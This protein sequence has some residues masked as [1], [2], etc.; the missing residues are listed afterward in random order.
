MRHMLQMCMVPRRRGAL[1]AGAIALLLALVGAAAPA[2]AGDLAITAFSCDVPTQQGYLVADDVSVQCSVTISESGLVLAPAGYPVRILLDSYTTVFGV[3]TSVAD[4]RVLDA[5][6]KLTN[7]LGGAKER[8]VV[9]TAVDDLTGDDMDAWLIDQWDAGRVLVLSA[10]VDPTDRIV[11]TDES[12]NTATM[13]PFL[14]SFR[15]APLSGKVAFGPATV[16][17]GAGHAQ[18]PGVCAAADLQLSADA[19]GTWRAGGAFGPLPVDMGKACVVVAS[20]GAGGLNLA[21][22]PGGILALPGLSASFG[23][24]QATIDVTLTGAGAVVS[25]GTLALPADHTFHEE[26]GGFPLPRG[27]RTLPM[28]TASLAGAGTLN[29]LKLSRSAG[30]LHAHGLPFYLHV[31]SI[32]ADRKRVE[33]LHSGTRWVHKRA[34]LNDDPRAPVVLG[35]SRV[36]SNDIRFANPAFIQANNRFRLAAAG[37][38]ATVTFGPGVGD[39]HFPQAS[40]AWLPVNLSIAKGAIKSQSLPGDVL[41]KMVQSATCGACT[42]GAL[43]DVAFAV[44][45]TGRMGIGSDGAVLARVDGLEDAAWGGFDPALGHVFERDGD[46]AHAGVLLF[47]GAIATGTGGVGGPSVASSLLGA[48]EAKVVSGALRPAAHHLLEDAATQKG[49][50]FVA[51]LTV[52]PALYDKAGAPVVGVGESLVGTTTRVRLGGL[53]QPGPCA[54]GPCELASNEATRFVVR[55]GGV[56]GVFDTDTPPTP[57]VYGYELPLTRFAFRQVLNTVDPVSGLEGAVSVPAPGEFTV[58]FES[59]GFDCTGALTEAVVPPCPVGGGADDP[60]C[61]ETLRAWKTRMDLLSMGFASIPGALVCEPGLRKLEVGSELDIR[62]LSA[63]LGL[64]AQ[65]LP[66]GTPTAVR[67]TGATDHVLDADAG[68]KVPGFPVALHPAPNLEWASIDDGWYAFTVDFATPLFDA[69]TADARLANTTLDTRA[70]TWVRA[71]G[72]DWTKEGPC[73]RA[74]FPDDDAALAACAPTAHYTWGATGFDVDLQAWYDGA[75]AGFTGVTREHSLAVMNIRAA[76]AQLTADAVTVTFGASAELEDLALAAIDLSIDLDDPAS[77]AKTDAYLA[78]IGVGGAPIGSIVE[79]VRGAVDGVL[80]SLGGELDLQLRGVIQGAIGAAADQVAGTVVGQTA[81][82]AAAELLLAVRGIPASFAAEASLSLEPLRAELTAGLTATLDAKARALFHAYASIFAR[83]ELAPCAVDPSLPCD[84]ALAQVRELREQ[85]ALIRGTLDDLAGRLADAEARLTALVD[86][87]QALTTDARAMLAALT[88][89]V[90]VDDATVT[91]FVSGDVTTNQLLGLLLY[92]LAPSLRDAME[93]F[94]VVD[95]VSNLSKLAELVPLPATVSEAQSDIRGTAEELIAD[96]DQTLVSFEAQ[97][98]L[99]DLSTILDGATGFLDDLDLLLAVASTQLGWLESALA[100]PFDALSDALSASDDLLAQA[101]A[102]LAGIEEDLLCAMDP[103]CLGVE[104]SAMASVAI[105]AELNARLKAAT[106]G[107]LAFVADVGGVE[108]SFVLQLV[109]VLGEPL[110]LAIAD[111][112]L[113]VEL[114]LP[115]LFDLP[116]FASAA[117]LRDTL[118]DLVMNAPGIEALILTFQQHF[119][120]LVVEVAALS[121]ELFDQVE[122]A[123]N[124]LATALED[125][126]NKVLAA[127]NGAIDDLTADLPIEAA[128]LDGVAVVA[129][130]ELSSLHVGAAWTMRGQQ[131]EDSRTFEAALDVTAWST[132]GKG[133]ACDGAASQSALLDAVISTRNLPLRVGAGEVTIETLELGFTLDGSTGVPKPVGLFGGITTDGGLD[134]ESFRI[135][136]IAFAAGAGLYE[137]Y[138]GAKASASFSAT[139][140]S[141]GFLVGRTC[142]LDVLESLDPQVAEFLTL[143]ASGFSGV[144]ARGSAGFPLIDLGC[145]LRLSLSADVGTWLLGGPPLVLGGLVGGGA[146]GKLGCIGALAGKATVYAEKAGAKVKFEGEGFGAA[147][148]GVDCDPETWTSVA[149]SRDD[150]KCG[151]GDASLSLTYEGGKWNVPKPHVSAV[152]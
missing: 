99:G 58:S 147:G 113:T 133:D 47:P 148:V 6:V 82:E 83:V 9:L 110:D 141:L 42:D 60:N 40:V 129:G 64:T 116:D 152:H 2:V 126:A 43:A 92:G 15:L 136:D 123:L 34:F 51:G 11:E 10:V 61:G 54:G 79:G 35:I 12:N 121:G 46:A 151:T 103:G 86:T 44:T 105:E 125:V 76:I 1:L 100:T 17:L 112:S 55:P 111:I 24:V 69:L 90:F 70:E 33:G 98:T 39:T 81:L 120:L 80:A 4:S 65:W 142:N 36:R 94:E 122:A 26:V 132:N 27:S 41:Q 137:T 78:T 91:G 77:I 73:T 48:R 29:G 23:G 149:K 67:V 68:A 115:V 134:F 52:G 102:V 93:T 5:W 95:L 87:A 20:S 135:Y 119:D 28:T 128:S 37:L 96:F 127:A 97:I 50:H 66:T 139:Q 31:A 7:P 104:V 146:S 32:T 84:E 72:A 30:F 108:Q 114:Q 56:T 140:L 144:Y 143:P 62:A 53:S 21:I 74:A 63:P 22:E 89:G 13:N 19:T 150:D 14:S 106:G 75:T 101:D 107:L 16:T 8:T 88:E 49:N 124:D 131:D 85:L 3:P 38:I 130:N 57:T 25:N 138:V 18:G 145:L 71:P 117:E 118:V 109:D 59:L 45:P